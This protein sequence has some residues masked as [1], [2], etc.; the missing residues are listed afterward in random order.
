MVTWL[1]SPG[2][3]D[4]IVAHLLRTRCLPPMAEISDGHPLPE[5]AWLSSLGRD[6]YLEMDRRLGQRSCTYMHGHRH[7]PHIILNFPEKP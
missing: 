1:R 3:D 2:L 6:H 7:T 5:I 4:L